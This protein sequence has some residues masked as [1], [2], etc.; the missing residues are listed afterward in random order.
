[1]RRGV[2]GSNAAIDNSVERAKS[3]DIMSTQTR[4]DL[5]RLTKI[6][7][8]LSMPSKYDTVVKC[9]KPCLYPN[10]LEDAAHVYLD[11]DK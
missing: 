8:I 1:M 7:D 4:Y 6:N 2:V 5:N 11:R 10:K 9:L 3:S